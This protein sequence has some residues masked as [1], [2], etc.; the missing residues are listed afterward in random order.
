MSAGSDRLAQSR[1]AILEHLRQK[2]ESG[3]PIRQAFRSAMT[4]MGLR[5]EAAPDAMRAATANGRPAPAPAPND[6]AAPA[7]TAPEAAHEPTAPPP[8]PDGSNPAARHE[9]RARELFGGRLH[10]VSEAGRAYWHNHPAR[11]V[12]ELATPALSSY[13][14]KHPARFIAISAAAGA[15]IY[16]AR[17][18]RLISVTGLMV[19][20][21][22]S[23]AV[24]GALISALYGQ[25]AG[26]VP[27]EGGPTE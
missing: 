14:Q 25:S 17:P 4:S 8:L 12:V 22:R 21:L 26:D 9:Q 24:S 7:A 6:T 16:I 19:A 5:R 20:A 1:L 10:A 3:G 23:P 15:A 27:P 2:Q 18:W 11:L 13:A